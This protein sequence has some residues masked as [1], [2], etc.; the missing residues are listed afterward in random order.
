M[1][2]RMYAGTVKPYPITSVALLVAY[3]DPNPDVVA[4]TIAHFEAIARFLGWE[5]KGVISQGEVSDKGDIK[6]KK[7]LTDAKKLGQNIT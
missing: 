6:G 3:G 4:P 1:I 7:S 2:D 5:N